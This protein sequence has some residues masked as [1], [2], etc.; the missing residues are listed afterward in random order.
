MNL[1]DI[2]KLIESL[3]VQL[4]LLLIYFPKT[5]IKIIK[6]PKW[7]ISYIDEQL[8]KTERFEN[9]V[10]P[11]ILFLIT[12]V[13]LFLIIR[14]QLELGA[15]IFNRAEKPENH[16]FDVIN[17]L[18]GFT[19]AIFGLAF[20]SIPLFFALLTEAIGF[21]KFTRDSLIRSLYVQCYYFSPL[22]L[23]VFSSFITIALMEEYMVHW[24][25]F[26]KGILISPISLIIVI[27]VI[28]FIVNEIRFISRELRNK[29]WKGALVFSLGIGFLIFGSVT[30]VIL[31][32][33]SVN[34]FPPGEP[35]SLVLGIPEPGNYKIQVRNDKYGYDALYVLSIQRSAYDLL[36]YPGGGSIEVGQKIRGSFAVYRGDFYR[37]QDQTH[38]MSIAE[39]P[40]DS[41]AELKLFITDSLKKIV[42]DTLPGRYIFKPPN[43]GQYTINLVRNTRTVNDSIEYQ[44]AVFDYKEEFEDQFYDR[45]NNSLPETLITYMR[46]SV[47]YPN[48]GF[49]EVGQKIM[50]Q[51]RGYG[52]WEFSRPDYYNR[53][54]ISVEPVNSI[55]QEFDPKIDVLDKQYNSVLLIRILPPILIILI[56]SLFGFAFF[57]GVRSMI[58]K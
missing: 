45:P 29:L 26:Y 34:N 32:N 2:L 39:L 21:K 44:L 49:I 6:D 57:L 18:Q 38:F 28:W 10:S 27:I 56:T 4:L 40:L 52:L 58:I 15:D 31:T 51:D 41:D 11:V 42:S 50:A 19:G 14:V 53:F 7:V 35:E 3:T 47:P 33:T 36:Y 20:L 1:V 25:D 46:D 54:I 37:W 55:D 5:I 43:I 9:Y 23:A 30:Y 24:P 17:S 16:F 48:D 22:I 12:T 8:D 13:I